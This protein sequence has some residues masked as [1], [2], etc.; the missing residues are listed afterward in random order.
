MAGAGIVVVPALRRGASRAAGR[1]QRLSTIVP[2]G[3]DIENPSLVPA[4]DDGGGYANVPE[5]LQEQ[6]TA[7]NDAPPVAGLVMLNGL[8]GARAEMRDDRLLLYVDTLPKKSA[9]V[10]TLRAVSRGGFVLPPLSAEGMYDTGIRAVT[11]PGKVTVHKKGELPE[12]NLE[13]K[14]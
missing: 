7:I 5:S 10:Y 1:S 2:G 14:P 12:Q 9:F 13:K 3:F 4:S 6:W 11:L 8:G